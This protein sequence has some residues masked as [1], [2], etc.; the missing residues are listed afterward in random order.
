MTDDVNNGVVENGGTIS[1]T[2]SP[3]FYFWIILIIVLLGIS[4]SS[5]FLFN[6]VH[7]VKNDSCVFFHYE[8][9]T[10]VF[11]Q[12]LNESQLLHKI[13][14]MSFTNRTLVNATVFFREISCNS[15]YYE[16]KKGLKI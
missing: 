11:G 1:K 2:P 13:H 8:D 12:V 5:V 14:V 10:V 4:L 16:N 9:E 6:S 3:F 15:S 7:K